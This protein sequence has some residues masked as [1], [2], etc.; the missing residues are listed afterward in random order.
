MLLKRKD[1][2]FCLRFLCDSSAVLAAILYTAKIDKQVLDKEMNKATADNDE[3]FMKM[4]K[5]TA[6]VMMSI[7]NALHDLVTTLQSEGM[8]SN[9][10]LFVN[11]D[12]GGDTLYA[13][14]RLLILNYR[15]LGI[16]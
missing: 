5:I 2:L 10:V 12:N 1:V 6:S 9:T 13:M 15:G 16:D 11:S 4:R 7:D 8:L 14:V 3:L